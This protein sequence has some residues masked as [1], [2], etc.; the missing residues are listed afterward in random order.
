VGQLVQPESNM[1]DEKQ[2]ESGTVSESNPGIPEFRDPG[3]FSN[4][5]I[6]G[7]RRSNPGPIPALSGLGKSDIRVSNCSKYCQNAYQYFRT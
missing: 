3:L 6:P 4:P 7:L 1:A 2:R 5:E